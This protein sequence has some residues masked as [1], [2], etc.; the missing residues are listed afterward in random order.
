MVAST[1]TKIGRGKGRPTTTG[2]VGKDALVTAAREVLKRKSPGEITLN[3]IAQIAGV[4]PALIRYYFGQL[5]GLYAEVASDITREL[6]AR[7]AATA[8]HKGSVQDRLH[9]RVRAYMEIFQANP[10]YNRLMIDAVR[11]TDNP[12][13]QTILG[14]VT[15]SI[16]EM[17]DLALEGERTGETKGLDGRF[18]QLAI[19][20]M[21]E[22]F[23]SAHPVFE[24]IF[25]TDA[26]DPKFA[27]AYS[28]FILSL[29]TCGEDNRA[30]GDRSGAHSKRQSKPM[31]SAVRHK[32]R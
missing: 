7:L 26:N 2:S 10:Y 32:R 24:A 30:N 22:F 8:T 18:L 5:S 23:F 6:R 9:R 28:R 14:L 16:E 15:Y 27:D 31:G 1:K 12:A 25:G 4:D 11:Q 29:V 20:A 13:R 19:V 17:K 3:E 21:G